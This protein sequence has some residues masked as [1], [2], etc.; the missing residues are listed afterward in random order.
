MSLVPE[1]NLDAF[2]RLRVSDPLTLFDSQLEYNAGPLFWEDV[3]TGTGAV[4]HS[5]DGALSTLTVA[6]GGDSVIR[7]TRAYFRYKPGKSQYVKMTGVFGDTP[8]DDLIRR[9]GYYD[10]DNGVFL[11]QD[12]DGVHWVLRSNTSGS[13]VDTKVA[14]SGWTVSAAPWL[15]VSKAFLAFIDFEWLGVGQVRCGFFLHGKPVIT[16]TFNTAP[17][18]AVPYMRTANLPVRYEISSATNETGAMKQICS[19][20]ISEGGFEE[21]SGT[22][23]ARDNTGSA[24]AIS[25][26]ERP[27][28]AIRP[29]ATFN[30]ITNRGVIRPISVALYSDAA[31]NWRVYYNATTTTAASWLSHGDDS[32]A[33]Y[34]IASTAVNTSGAIPIASG[35]LAASSGGN[36]SPGT[37]GDSLASRL[38]VVLD[39]AGANPIEIVVTMTTLSGAGNGYAGIGWREFY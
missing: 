19:A 17:S 3:T 25:T 29:K 16:H 11:Q 35:F 28:L 7:Q 27:V 15:D 24:T 30:S 20:V 18:L 37:A 9:V 12:S 21:E 23:Q 31:C 8:T 36:G 14:Q 33:E 39:A 5:A 38:P 34:D 1:D 4:A 32:I 10:G 6:A 22:P 2:G 26:T 13:A